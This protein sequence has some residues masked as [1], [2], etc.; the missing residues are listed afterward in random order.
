MFLTRDTASRGPALP[1]TRLLDWS[2]NR[3]RVAAPESAGGI[4]RSFNTRLGS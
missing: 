1:V 4:E 3:T 2:A